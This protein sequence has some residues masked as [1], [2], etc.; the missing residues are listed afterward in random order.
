MSNIFIA[1]FAYLIDK[2]FGE[3]PVKHPVSAMGEMITFFEENFYQDS[4]LRGFL[5]VVFMVVA[6]GTASIAVHLYLAYL[7]DFYKHIHLF[8]DSINVYSSQDALR[9]CKRDSELT[10]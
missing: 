1:V 6:I 9:F 5:L 4:I 3:F 8:S 2:V 7:P 10:E